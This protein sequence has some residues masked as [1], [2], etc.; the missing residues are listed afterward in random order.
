MIS[1]R[2][3]VI[4]T[5]LA[6]AAGAVGLWTLGRARASVD[7]TGAEAVPVAGAPD[8]LRIFVTMRNAGAA[9]RLIGATLDGIAA[10]TVSDGDLILPA[11]SSPSLAADGAHLLVRGLP[12]PGEGAIL[13]LT[14]TF[15]GAGAVATR[16]RVA[17]ALRPGDASAF[18]LMSLGGICR[19]GPGE[20]APEV[21][22]NL[23]AVDGGWRMH[24]ASSNFTFSEPAPDLGHIPGYG[25]GHLYLNGLKLQR[26]YSDT[27]RIG[28]L[29]PG[30]YAVS[31]TLNTNDHRAYV[32]GDTPVRATATLRVG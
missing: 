29:A 2:R 25:H 6:G 32:V 9:D 11:G 12:P 31:V 27:A 18:G 14:L 21:A 26:M 19:A 17:P 22:L 23:T 4:L 7:L 8:E 30:D 5:G 16:A 1:R 10:E 3:A 28:A 15:A 13:P 24:V 20:P